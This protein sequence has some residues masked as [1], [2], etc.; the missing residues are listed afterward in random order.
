MHSFEQGASSG[1]GASLFDSQYV[2]DIAGWRVQNLDVHS[3]FG[4][5]GKLVAAVPPSCGVGF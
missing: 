4:V 5:R 2:I 1:W 3:A